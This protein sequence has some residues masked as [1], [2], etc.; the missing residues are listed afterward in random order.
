MSPNLFACL[1]V[2]LMHD[3]WKNTHFSKYV[4]IFKSLGIKMWFADWIHPIIKLEVGILWNV[5]PY[6]PCFKVV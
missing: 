5:I 3:D 6:Q 1:S 2:C 4:E